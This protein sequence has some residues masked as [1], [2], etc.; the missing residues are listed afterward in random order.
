MLTMA[1]LA[2]IGICA[3]VLPIWMAQAQLLVPRT[4]DQ[5]T[6]LTAQ[7]LAAIRD[8]VDSRIHGRAP[9]TR[10]HWSNPAGHSGTVT[11]LGKTMR[12]GMPCERIEY[13]IAEAQPNP[14]HG[15]FVVTSCQLPD[16]SWKFAD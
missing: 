11:L 9:G 1:R 5:A 15:T 13:R 6:P 4:W 16:G 7:D 2:F 10:A 12:H 8:A 14:P 3:I